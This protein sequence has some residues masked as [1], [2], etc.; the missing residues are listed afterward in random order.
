MSLRWSLRRCWQ[1]TGLLAALVCPPALAAEATLEAA[2]IYRLV[3]YSDWPAPQ[4]RVYC[5]VHETAVQQALQQVLGQQVVVR[6][7]EQPRQSRGC[8]VLYLSSLVPPHPDWQP[9]LQSADLLSIAGNAELFAL[10]TIFG[11]IQEPQQMAF[12]VNL[13]LA[14]SREHQLNTRMLRLAKELY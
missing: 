3:Q 14:R 4:P 13:T 1:L 12:R 11:I 5:V 8:H 2:L 9:I 6:H 10:G 7:I